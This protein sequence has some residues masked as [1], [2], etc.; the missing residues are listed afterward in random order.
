MDQRLEFVLE[1]FQRFI[2]FLGSL[3]HR[4]GFCDAFEARSGFVNCR[5]LHFPEKACQHGNDLIFTPDTFAR[6]LA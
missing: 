2:D 4:K 5:V 6:G 3:L 1:R